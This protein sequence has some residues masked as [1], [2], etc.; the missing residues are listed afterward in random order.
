MSDMLHLAWGVRYVRDALKTM[1]GELG[2]GEETHPYI[3]IALKVA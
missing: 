3:P 2:C 1:L